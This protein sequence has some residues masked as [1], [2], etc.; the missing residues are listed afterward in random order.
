MAWTY[1]ISNLSGK[2]ILEHF[3]KK[4]YKEQIKENLEIGK[5]LRGKLINYISNGKVM[6]ILL[7]VALIKKILSYKKIL[8]KIK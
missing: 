2:E 7:T 5:L 4:N 3:T 8:V 6:W 1:V